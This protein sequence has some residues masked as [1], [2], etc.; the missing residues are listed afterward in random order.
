VVVGALSKEAEVAFAGGVR[1]QQVRGALLTAKGETQSSFLK[2][3]RARKGVLNL[4]VPGEMMTDP[5][6]LVATAVR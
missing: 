6:D 2:V 3:T 4:V 1:I 5:I